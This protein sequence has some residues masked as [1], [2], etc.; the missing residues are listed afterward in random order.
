VLFGDVCFEPSEHGVEG[1]G[2]LAELVL[3]QGVVGFPTRTK[4]GRDTRVLAWDDE[5]EKVLYLR[6]WREVVTDDSQRPLAALSLPPLS[7][8]RLA[9]D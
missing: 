7:R 1:L 3:E 6:R 2:E 5:K 4:R 9:S 8:G